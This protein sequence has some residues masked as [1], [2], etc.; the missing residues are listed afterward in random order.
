MEILNID[1]LGL[2]EA[3]E[4]KKCE[5]K[6]TVELAN[7]VNREEEKMIKVANFAEEPKNR[8]NYYGLDI[9]FI[10][11]TTASMSSII[12]GSKASI[13]AIIEDA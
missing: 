8:E 6:I 9:C 7:N 1:Q 10:L 13:K 3:F 11:D 2:D 12:E 5:I 4:S